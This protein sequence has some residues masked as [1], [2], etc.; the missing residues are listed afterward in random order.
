MAVFSRKT[1]KLVSTLTCGPIAHNLL[2]ICVHISDLYA[3]TSLLK[4]GLTI[5][6]FPDPVTV[7]LAV[8]PLKT[9][10]H[11]EQNNQVFQLGSKAGLWGLIHDSSEWCCG[12]RERAD[13][14][15]R[16]STGAAA[17]P[18]SEAG[19]SRWWP[20]PHHSEPAGR[21]CYECP[22]APPYHTHTRPLKPSDTSWVCCCPQE[23]C[24]H[25]RRSKHEQRSELSHISFKSDHVYSSFHLFFNLLC[26]CWH[27]LSHTQTHSQE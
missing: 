12:E 23:G 27:H 5:L 22:T 8:R 7:P 6:Q 1:K 13:T 24:P 26:S 4:I 18:T 25:K 10:P 19:T 11:R 9:S 14:G 16:R 21:S 20:A 3:V 15:K 2:L 17:A